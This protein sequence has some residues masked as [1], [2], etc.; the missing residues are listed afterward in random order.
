MAY[1]QQQQLATSWSMMS[2]SQAF[3]TG[4]SAPASQPAML[5][6]DQPA[7]DP[8]NAPDSHRWSAPSLSQPASQAAISDAMMANRTSGTPLLGP[9]LYDS[10]YDTEPASYGTGSSSYGSRPSSPHASMQAPFTTI[11]PHGLSV[12]M[13]P[14]QSLNISL[15]QADRRASLQ[16]AAAGVPQP[17]QWQA[18]HGHGRVMTA[19]LPWMANTTTAQLQPPPAAASVLQPHYRQVLSA[20]IASTPGNADTRW[21]LGLN[22]GGPRRSGHNS[23][24]RHTN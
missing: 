11:T 3:H 14:M 18:D 13:M 22:N 2:H 9:S 19:P 16:P 12:P 24:T 15:Q 23:D 21:P 20:A 7:G 5:I 17:P 4:S 6:S 1:Q 10:S 8:W